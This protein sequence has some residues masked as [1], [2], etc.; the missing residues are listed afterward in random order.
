MDL[1]FLTPQL[2][3]PAH[4]GTSLR[5]LHIIRGLADDNRIT[6]LSFAEEGE[7]QEIAPQLSALCEHVVTVPAP[8]RSMRRR[9]WQLVSSG[10]PD[11]ALR[12]YSPEF[13]AALASLLNSRSFDIVQIEGIEMSWTVPVLQQ[14]APKLPLVYDAH[15]AETLLQARS[16][17]A[18][19]KRI[20]RWPA[21]IYS[22]L[23]SSR[24]AS[25]EAWVCNTAD[26]VTAV[27][28][29][30]REA[31]QNLAGLPNN[32][33]TVI[34]NSIDVSAYQTAEAPPA[35]QYRFD[36]VFSGKMDYRP[37]IDAVL[38][39][40][41]AVWPL[42][43]KEVPTATWAVVGQKP[44][45][46]LAGL[47]QLPD[48]TVTG[49]VPEVQPYLSGAT[50]F[51]MPFRV[52]SGTRLKLIEA[53]AAGKAVVST[54]VGV[55]GFPVEDGRQLLVSDTAPEFAASTVTLLKNAEQRTALGVQGQLFAQRYDWRIIIPRFQ[56]LYDEI[57]M[58]TR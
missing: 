53:L 23:Q 44:H 42:I 35:Q 10:Q 20:Q 11:M 3:Y 9:L 28:E 1:L 45:A 7:G 16:G 49:W 29:A 52:G 48:V 43:K 37:N 41:E 15:N 30:D 47:A 25:Y 46:R 18:D 54:R 56:S 12:L 58:E 33:V 31:L 19:K 27:S 40:A 55:E 34:P 26:R 24:L 51:V 32:A 22:S 8:Q 6:L 14:A 17:A 39:F 5:N 50:V 13:S 57:G 4:Q 21:V 2:P 36:V 38:W